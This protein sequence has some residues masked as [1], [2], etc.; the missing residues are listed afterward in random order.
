VNPS[1]GAAPS[2]GRKE[3]SVSSRS[4]HMPYLSIR[5][6][7]SSLLSSM[8]R[9]FL[10]Q[11]QRTGERECERNQKATNKKQEKE[12]DNALYL[13]SSLHGFFNSGKSDTK[14]RK[15]L[16]TDNEK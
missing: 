15:K 11:K 1:L 14:R 10:I 2:G 13:F 3:G 5:Y 7:S 8:E 4:F 6:T 16:S 12:R 9:G